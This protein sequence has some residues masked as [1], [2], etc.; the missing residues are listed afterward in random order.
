[1]RLSICLWKPNAIWKSNLLLF[2]FYK[3]NVTIFHIVDFTYVYYVLGMQI[4][5]VRFA[6]NRTIFMKCRHFNIKM[7][8]SYQQISEFFFI[9]SWCHPLSLTLTYFPFLFYMALWTLRGEVWWRYQ[10]ELSVPKVFPLFTLS[11]CEFSQIVVSIYCRRILLSWWLRQTLTW[12]SAPCYHWCF[13]V[14]KA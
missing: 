12:A 8:K 1:M 7:G 4:L 6:W 2:I 10:L 9:I 14:D 11:I 13:L 3:E 5:A